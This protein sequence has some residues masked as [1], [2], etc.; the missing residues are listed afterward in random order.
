MQGRIY[1]AL[2]Q[3]KSRTVALTVAL[4]EEGRRF[5]EAARLLG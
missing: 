2:R 4:K 5:E 1:A 3:A